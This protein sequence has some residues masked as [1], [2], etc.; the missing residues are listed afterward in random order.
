M[1]QYREILQKA[2][3]F[4]GFEDGDLFRVLDCLQAYRQEFEK[5]QVI[6]MAGQPVAEVGVLLRGRAQLVREEYTGE[7]S[8]LAE[9]RPGELFAEAYACA[10]PEKADA[11]R[12]PVTV[13]AVAQSTVMK[14]DYRRIITTCSSACSFHT[15]LIE[16]MLGVMAEKNIRLNRTIGHLSKR[17][18]REKLLSYL[19]EQASMQNSRVFCIP[20]NRQ[21]L[22]DYL[23]VERSAMSS[24]LGKLRDEGVIRVDRNRFELL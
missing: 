1:I 15:R 9:V 16:N 3:L 14:M 11:H 10:P 24:A 2:P 19:S 5:N 13:V 17:S 12:I 7:R 6:L 21:E 8:I 20:F 18:T 4:Q 22:A 23:C